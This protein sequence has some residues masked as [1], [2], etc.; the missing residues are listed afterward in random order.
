MKREWGIARGAEE[1][2]GRQAY[3]A[4]KGE[5]S[6]GFRLAYELMAHGQLIPRCKLCPRA[7]ARG[8]T[9]PSLVPFHQHEANGPS[10]PFHDHDPAA[11]R[12]VERPPLLRSAGEPGAGARRDHA[13]DRGQGV[14]R[15]HGA[16][17]LRQEHAHAPARR[18]GHAE[19]GRNL[20][21]RPAPAPRGRKGAHPV[22]PPG[23]GHRVP[24]V[25]PAADHERAGKRLPAADA[26]GPVAGKASVRT[27]WRCSTAW[28]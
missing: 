13:G 10:S 17:R 24:I 11:I 4:R 22:P 6:H 20:R 23:P 25:Q 27:R 5:V 1:P 28:A 12:L 14:R 9:H 21:R 8:R 16:E 15:H 18:T 26:R 3:D 7:R 2:A 19:R